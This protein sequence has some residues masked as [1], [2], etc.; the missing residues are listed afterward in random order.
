MS[1]EVRQALPSEK[2]AEVGSL[3]MLEGTFDEEVSD[4]SL[5]V[6]AWVYIS[7]FA[8]IALCWSTAVLAP[9]VGGLL[10]ASVAFL[11]GSWVIASRA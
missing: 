6:G 9:W 7:A 3:P 5:A 4:P 8:G 10:S 2:S 1:T 11:A